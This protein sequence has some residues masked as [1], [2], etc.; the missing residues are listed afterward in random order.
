M[1]SL[2]QHTTITDAIL[3]L[4]SCTRQGARFIRRSGDAKFYPYKDVLAR[5]MSCAGTLQA[6]GLRKGDRVAVILPTS[7]EFLDSFLGVILA[8]GIPALLYPPIQLGKLDEYFARTQ[9]M[10]EKIDAKV[11]LTD[12]LIRMLI[13][14]LWRSRLRRF[15]GRSLMPTSWHAGLSEWT[16]VEADAESPAFLQFSP[17][18]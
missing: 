18:Y 12:R 1:A 16:P 13:G 14:L 8:G 3:E 9:R 7:V 6:R 10:L 15:P 2:R 4:D 5:A 11:L 17:A